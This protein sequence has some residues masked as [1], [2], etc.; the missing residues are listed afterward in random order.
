MNQQT[1]LSSF[2]FQTKLFS[3]SRL[4]KVSHM[5][6]T[7]LFFFSENLYFTST[8]FVFFLVKPQ[9]Q[10]L[11]CSLLK[12][13]CTATMFFF[14]VLETR[15]FSFNWANIAF[16]FYSD[17]KQWFLLVYNSLQAFA[18]E[19]Q[20]LIVLRFLFLYFPLRTNFQ[21][22]EDVFF[23]NFCVEIIH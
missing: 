23:F 21:Q 17:Q 6:K 10:V 5:E 12:F 15:G 20:L 22:N 19:K 14:C 18:E 9:N 3:R 11:R 16:F 4:L 8:S 7:K 13:T 2:F 1:K